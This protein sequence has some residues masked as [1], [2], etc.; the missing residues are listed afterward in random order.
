MSTAKRIIDAATPRRIVAFL[1]VGAFADPIFSVLR[2]FA[3]ICWALKD[4]PT[5]RAFLLSGAGLAI[6]VGF[7]YLLL[8]GLGSAL[9]RIRR[10]QMA[11]AGEPV[12]EGNDPAAT[13]DCVDGAGG[14]VGGWSYG[15]G[16]DGHGR[17]Y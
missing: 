11:L 12:P 13:V 5:L 14:A 15:G 2:W 17:D 6:E 1:I 9:G 10:S 8:R 16:E 7:I 3:S 4:V